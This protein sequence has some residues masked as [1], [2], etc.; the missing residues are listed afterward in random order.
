MSSLYRGGKFFFGPPPILVVNSFSYLLLLL[1]QW[2][3]LQ[4]FLPLHKKTPST[5]L[6]LWRLL[7]TRTPLLHIPSD[8]LDA[9]FSMEKADSGEASPTSMGKKRVE[10]VT[11]PLVTPRGPAPSFYTKPTNRVGFPQQTRR[12]CSDYRRG[13]RCKGWWWRGRW[14]TRCHLS[15]GPDRLF[16]FLPRWEDSARLRVYSGHT[17]QAE[18]GV[19]DLYY[20]CRVIRLTLH[21]VDG[22]PILCKIFN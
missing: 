8:S 10:M 9:L 15:R 18:G 19:Q 2:H 12:P 14:R 5:K 13:G 22:N 3:L 11:T 6:T 4:N 17:H 16:R 20:T 7:R 21:P 1:S